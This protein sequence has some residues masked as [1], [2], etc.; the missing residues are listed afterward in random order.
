MERKAGIGSDG[1]IPG[2]RVVAWW[3]STPGPPNQVDPGTKGGGNG[4]VVCSNILG[5]V[6]A[7]EPVALYRRS[8]GGGGGRGHYIQRVLHVHWQHEHP[9][10]ATAEQYMDYYLT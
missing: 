9:G 8:L 2:I 1:W 4:A 3:I 5:L 10:H 6:C 7:K